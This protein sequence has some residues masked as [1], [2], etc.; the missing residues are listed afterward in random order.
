M[1]RSLGG[2]VLIF[3][4]AACGSAAGANPSDSP[5]A[6]AAVSRVLVSPTAS[7]V[8]SPAS[9]APT[10]S[11]LSRPSFAVLVDLLTD[12]GKYTATL[13]DDRARTFV[14]ITA[15]QRTPIS[16]AGGHALTLPYVSASSTA[17]YYLDGDSI[18]RRY[19]LDLKTSQVA[20]LDVSAGMEAAFAVSPDDVTMAVT[21]LDFN[22]SPVHL[23]LYTQDMNAGGSKRVIFQSDADYVW[24]VAWHAGML[25]LAHAFGPFEEQISVAAPG[26]DN[27]YSAISYHLVDPTNANRLMLMGS[28]SV[29]GA[30]SPAGSGCIQ[31]GAIDWQNNT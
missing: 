26:R 6:S 23:T 12:P 19:G 8:P 30:L 22:K 3:V 15:A 10:S 16:A 28:C 29:S 25:V 11:A 14:S 7:N 4:L 27:P 24:P 13:L 21:V 17:L 1:R 2:C 31:G 20:H 5:A 9:S 18:V